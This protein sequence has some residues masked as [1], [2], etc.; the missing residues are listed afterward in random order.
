M[1]IFWLFIMIG[2][3]APAGGLAR[4]AANDQKTQ[5][6]I[7]EL[8]AL[9]DQAEQSRSASYRFIDQLRDLTARYDWPWSRQILFDDFGDG[10]FRR[11]PAW[12]SNS[13]AFWV[14][15]SVG[16]RTQVSAEKRS[17]AREPSSEEA[18]IG[19]L[20][21][22]VLK[23]KSNQPVASKRGRAE[24]YA[25]TPISNAFAIALELGSLGRGSHG[26]SF[27]WGPY[28]A[29]SLDSG[30]RLMYQGGSR[31]VLKLLRFR[32][33]A[34]SVIDL[35][36]HGSLLEDGAMHKIEWQRA[37]GG[38]MTVLLDG[39]QIIQVQDRSYR[40]PFSG[41]IMTNRGG[42]Y[43]VRSISIFGSGGS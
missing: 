8:K 12:N 3:L 15:R 7:N 6:L 18:M 35:Y 25:A 13:D 11:N 33:G 37:H 9:T 23:Q 43:A 40:H 4:A 29:Q 24:I 1:K 2:L 42:D 36:E 21:G 38:R 14:S 5:Q 19:L 32:S 41:F 20:L 31:P 17:A 30:Y 16:L 22:S 28:Q 26:G 34:S 27:E 39:R 10:D